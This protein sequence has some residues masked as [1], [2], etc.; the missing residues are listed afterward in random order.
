MVK[1]TK[2]LRAAFIESRKAGNEGLVLKDPDALYQ[3]GYHDN[4][5]KLKSYKSDDYRIAGFQEGSG[6]LANTLGAFIISVD[7]QNECF[8]GTGLDD[9]LRKKIWGKRNHYLNKIIEIKYK[10]KTKAGK[11]REPVFMRLRTDK[12]P[13]LC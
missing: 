3:F 7:G 9:D 4:W 12:D 2:Q 13:I 5:Q 1:N 6:R 11:L 10:E 8:I